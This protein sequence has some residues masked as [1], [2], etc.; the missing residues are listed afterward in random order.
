M[1][2]LLV[3]GVAII[4]VSITRMGNAAKIITSVSITAASLLAIITFDRWSNKEIHE[5][6]RSSE[7]R[8]FSDAPYVPY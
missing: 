5:T 3:G 7:P 2:I 8:V 4:L 6:V 1:M